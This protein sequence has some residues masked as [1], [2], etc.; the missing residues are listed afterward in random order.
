MELFGGRKRW[1]SE[2]PKRP[3]QEAQPGSGRGQPIFNIIRLLI[4]LLFAIL[5]IQLIRLQIIKGDEYE[6]RAAINALREVPIPSARGLLYDRQGQP[7][8]QNI[9][10]FSAA[11]VPGN[12]PQEGEMAV[13]DRLAAIL[14]MQPSEIQE[15]VRQHLTQESPYMPVVIKEGIAD[16]T[17]L[18]LQELE[19]YLTGVELLIEPARRY[20]SGPL[21]SHILGY[22]GEISPEEYE[23]QR[24]TGYQL[25][26]RIGKAGVELA[27]ETLLRGTPG[28]KLIEVD[29]RGRELRV[30]SERRPVDGS[31]LVLTIDLQLQ[32]QVQQVLESYAAGSDNAAAVVM[33][34]HT[35]DILAMVSLPTYD[36]NTFSQPL[37]EQVWNELLNAPGKPLVNHAIAEMYPPGSTFKTIVGSAA[38]QE[39]V[40][41]PGTVIVSR[42]FITVPN[43]FDPSVTY[44]FRDWAALGAMDFYRGLAMSSDVYFYYLAG[45][46]ADEGFAG[47]GE[48]RLANYAR[49]FGL[50]EPTGIDLPS[51]SPGL[52]PDARW[53]EQTIGETW[54]VGD[55]YN[56]G[57]GQGY[58]AVTP[59]QLITAV[60]PIANGGEVVRPH[61]LKQVRDSHGNIVQEATTD[62]KRQVPVDAGYLE[63]V[64]QGMQQ[65]VTQGVANTAQVPGLNI[66]GKTGTAEFGPPRPDGSHATHGWFVGFAPYEDPQVAVMVFVQR[67]GGG[68]QAA[69]AAARIFDYFFHGSNLAR[70]L[71]EG[72]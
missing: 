66:A 21:T 17:A 53:K 8:V 9:A 52:V 1:R 72:R 37:S 25:Q 27:Y 3:A 38:L 14:G 41:S 55:T 42:G 35:G 30:I 65:S 10:G 12:L 63:I 40:A 5:T 36:N 31:N 49:A 68:Q 70:E 43:Q 15:K 58:L 18:I 57:I 19:P 51:E 23:S 13:Y 56:F 45:G 7:L 71:G 46:K 69:P 6:Q 11:I 26:D 34:V 60:A 62:V 39:G 33:D 47:L 59:L 67:G 54:F 50:G 29:A 61:L 22:V 16:D 2:K 4:I 44:V 20:V 64:G 32:Q 28:R 24:E 48:E